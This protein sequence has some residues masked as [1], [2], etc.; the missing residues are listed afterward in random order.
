MICSRMGLPSP[1]LGDMNSPP[2]RPPSTSPPASSRLVTGGDKEP[3]VN[4]ASLFG[5]KSKEEGKESTAEGKESSTAKGDAEQG[6]LPSACGDDSLMV[7]SP[8]KELEVAEE[9]EIAKFAGTNVS[10]G[11][12]R[13]RGRG[14]ATAMKRPSA[15]SPPKS[16]KRASFKRPASFLEPHAGSADGGDEINEI[17]EG[18]TPGP[19]PDTTSAEPAPVLPST[20]RRKKGTAKGNLLKTV[21]DWQALP[22]C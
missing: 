22:C 5:G 4:P 15:G 10:R 18:T 20:V 7:A 19:T 16:C 2:P 6:N 1:H 3:L 8:D 9:A 11:R 13:G 14:R 17:T 21:G 12:G